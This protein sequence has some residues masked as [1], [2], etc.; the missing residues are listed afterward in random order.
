M[1]PPSLP[2]SVLE[3]VLEQ[4]AESVL[5]TDASG[6]I[7]YV[8]QAFE[9]LTG[10]SREEVLGQNPRFLKSGAH[11]QEFYRMFWEQIRAGV[12]YRGLFVNRKKD[13]TLFTEEKIVTP[14][15]DPSGSISYFVATSRDV[16]GEIAFQT[17]LR[18]LTTHDPLTRLLNRKAF[19]ERVERDLATPVRGMALAC[20]DL[21]RFQMVNDLLGH[22]GGD[23]V[24]AEVGRRLLAA[25]PE[26]V[27][28]RVGGDEFAAWYPAEGP[29]EARGKG[30]IL[31]ETLA[32]EVP[33]QGQP[34][35]LECSMGIALFPQHGASFTD[36]LRRADLAMHR[37][38]LFRTW[39]P[40][41]FTPDL[42]GLT[43]QALALETSFRE[44]LSLGRA[45]LV[46]QSL[47]DLRDKTFRNAEVLFRIR[48]SEGLS[49][50]L[51]HLDLSRRSVNEPLDRFVI[52]QARGLQEKY[53]DLTLW[54]NVTP[55]S[56]GDPTFLAFVHREVEEG[57]EPERVV[58][59]INERLAQPQLARIVPALWK[60][61][62]Q[63]FRLALDDFGS[64]QL[65]LVHLQS[66]PLNFLK[67]DRELFWSH[68][69]DGPH[70]P[71]V[72]A[73][74]V[75]MARDLGLGV[76]L[77]GVETESDLALAQALGVDLVQGFYLHA[78]DSEPRDPGQVL[79]WP[80]KP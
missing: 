35:R 12:P 3:A 16:T 32:L 69:G 20:L 46:F 1:N 45:Q 36:L 23:A 14:V 2:P 34:V 77:E 73:H 33:V 28:G 60:L 27:L 9:H 6:R 39:E 71:P 68:R 37:A 78:P 53:P 4:L 80:D 52:G 18:E 21:D 64:G 26:A 40:E 10:Y 42:E 51:P 55:W 79:D 29:D 70:P 41:V 15:R 17:R 59:E 38:K 24:L 11:S 61:R 13:G 44:A 74:I 57:L 19:L 72:I 63:G 58:L 54:L 49:N 65:S 76:A 75:A 31:L 43:P 8:N 47:L 5:I 25:L 66:L 22:R 48:G 30:R 7:L 62:A 50:P 67:I 56:L